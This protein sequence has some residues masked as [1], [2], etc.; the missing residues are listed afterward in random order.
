MDNQ[1]ISGG[2]QHAP[3][4]PLPHSQGG[5]HNPLP[6]DIEAII[7]ERIHQERMSWEAE[8]ATQDHTRSSRVG[9]PSHQGYSRY[10]DNESSIETKKRETFL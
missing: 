6:A 1:N 8:R 10:T 5:Q 3:V 7:Q 2:N 9:N 4:T